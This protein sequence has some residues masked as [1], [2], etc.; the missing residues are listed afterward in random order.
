MLELLK[1]AIKGYSILEDTMYSLKL[2]IVKNKAI[3]PNSE[4]AVAIKFEAKNFFHLF[5]FHYLENLDSSVNKKVMFKNFRNLVYRN[6]S[7]EQS[8]YYKQIV[9]SPVFSTSLIQ[10]RLE[11]IRDLPYFLDRFSKKNT[12]WY[13]EEFRGIT[14]G[15]DWDYLI[16]LNSE[17]SLTDSERYLFLRQSDESDYFVPISA[18]SQSRT[19]VSDFINYPKDPKR[20]D[21]LS[22]SKIC[23]SLK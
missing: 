13:Y 20:Y 2:G 18:F 14:T 5:G 17:E 12:Y 9:S 16:V 10:K 3:V 11:L 4:I 6:I 15:I 23:L 22:V 7:L 8:R 19:P 21:V 1:E